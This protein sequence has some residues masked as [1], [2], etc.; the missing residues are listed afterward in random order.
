[1]NSTWQIVKHNEFLVLKRGRDQ[2]VF[3]FPELG[4]S[5]R[6]QVILCGGWKF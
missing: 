6:N 4:I 2:K 1:M 5:L 3:P